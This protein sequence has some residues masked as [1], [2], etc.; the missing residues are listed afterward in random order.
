MPCNAYGINDNYDSKS[1]HFFP[2][3]IKKI[4][5]ARRKK[6]DYIKIWGSGKALREVIY[7]D[8][9]ADACIFFL[10]KKTSKSLIN[11]GT[12]IE[13]SI[14]QYAKFIM[15]HLGVNLSIAYE[16]QK[17]E[18]TYRKLLDVSLAKKY[19][20]TYKTSLELGLSKTIIDYL[21]KNVLSNSKKIKV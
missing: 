5:E 7:S 19:G 13:K 3:L 6:K 1:S 10:K 9:I 8:D 14:T 18:G 15:K 2:A 16:K 11:I 21:K 4:I 20:W 12:G 17:L